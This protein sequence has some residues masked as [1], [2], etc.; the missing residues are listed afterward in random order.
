MTLTR[1][2]DAPF[3]CDLAQVVEHSKDNRV[4]FTCNTRTPTSTRF[5]IGSLSQ[6]FGRRSGSKKSLTGFAFYLY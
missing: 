1:S 3:D 5:V 6:T 2:S 4:F